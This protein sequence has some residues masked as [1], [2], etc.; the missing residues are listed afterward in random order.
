MFEILKTKL[1]NVQHKLNLK[2]FGSNEGGYAEAMKG[3]IVAIVA[4]VVIALLVS[5]LVPGAINAITNTSTV[6]WASGTTSMWT[7]IPLFLVLTI[8]LIFVGLALAVF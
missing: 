3:A 5:A 7:A 8:V 6:G 1:E 2:A 4:I